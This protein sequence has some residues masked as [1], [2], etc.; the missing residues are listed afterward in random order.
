MPS[1]LQTLFIK[2]FNHFEMWEIEL[3][4]NEEISP[5]F[6]SLSRKSFCMNDRKITITLDVSCRHIS[7]LLES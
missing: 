6:F 7:L 4:T 5:S 1:A 3:K 2:G